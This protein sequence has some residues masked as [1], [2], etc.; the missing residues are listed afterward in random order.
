MKEKLFLSP[1]LEVRTSPIEGRGVFCTE[2]IKKGDIIEEAHLFLLKNNKWEECD[3]ALK[4]YALPW[5]ELREDWKE[6]C[7]KHEGILSQHATRPVV[8][9]GFGMIYNH[10]DENNV[11]YFIDKHR[12]ICSYKANRDIDAQSELTIDYGADYFE[13]S[14]IKKR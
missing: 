2:N 1:V 4:R 5:V 6:F 7:D 14:K 11:D 12:L 13:L 8:V 10:A 3:A 9:L